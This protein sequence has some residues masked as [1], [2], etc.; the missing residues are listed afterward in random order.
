MFCEADTTQNGIRQ[1][2][3]CRCVFPA[4]PEKEAENEKH[5]L[6]V[7]R[8]N[9]CGNVECEGTRFSATQDVLKGATTHSEVASIVHAE[10]TRRS[11]AGVGDERFTPIALEAEKEAELLPCPFCGMPMNE[12]LAYSVHAKGCYLISLTRDAEAWNRRAVK[13]SSTAAQYEIFEAGWNA[14]FQ[15][16]LEPDRFPTQNRCEVRYREIYSPSTAEAVK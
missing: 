12:G 16:A 13:E 11:V 8:E 4:T 14:G 3:G 15:E 2:C 5:L 9:L 10:M 7:Y 1:P 6:Q